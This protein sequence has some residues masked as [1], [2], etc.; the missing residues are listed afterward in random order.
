MLSVKTVS[1]LTESL[2]IFAPLFGS[3]IPDRIP[4][5]RQPSRPLFGRWTLQWFRSGENGT[6][7]CCHGSF[8]GQ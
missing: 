5:I 4:Q 2:R 3:R 1:C 6:A 8:T 7:N